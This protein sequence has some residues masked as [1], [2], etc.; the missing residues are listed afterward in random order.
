[1]V[2]PYRRQ[3]WYK[4]TFPEPRQS[5]E[6]LKFGKILPIWKAKY[7]GRSSYDAR[8]ICVKQATHPFERLINRIIC[9][10]PG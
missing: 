3:R 4:C 8:G 2:I 1:L 6:K 7:N 10:Y 9:R 5:S